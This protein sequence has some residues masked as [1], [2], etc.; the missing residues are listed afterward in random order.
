MNELIFLALQQTQG[1]AR[2]AG[3]MDMLFPL[4]LMF[5]VFYFLMIRPQQ[6][7]QRE[8]QEMVNRLAKGDRVVTNGG[9]LGTVAK[10]DDEVIT[11]EVGDRTKVK[12]LKGQ[13]QL[14]GSAESGAGKDG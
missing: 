12:V 5:L 10:V 14:Y 6:K 4:A 11:L 8:H 3:F 2:Q 7:R 1:G 9:L 13:V